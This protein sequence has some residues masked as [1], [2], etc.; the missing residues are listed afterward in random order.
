MKVELVKPKL[1]AYW[2]STKLKWKSTSKR[3]PKLLFLSSSCK[4][5]MNSLVNR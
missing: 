3:Q 2:R 4:G 5:K 1:W